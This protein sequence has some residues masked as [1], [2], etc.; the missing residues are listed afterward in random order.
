MDDQ[1]M[2]DSIRQSIP[3]FMN[4]EKM[5]SFVSAAPSTNSFYQP[6][7]GCTQSPEA[8][9][10]LKHPIEEDSEWQKREKLA[11]A[12]LYAPVAFVI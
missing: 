7:P 10:N 3:H 12:R 2:N 6:D 8:D 4:A 1:N 9:Q 5:T 11:K